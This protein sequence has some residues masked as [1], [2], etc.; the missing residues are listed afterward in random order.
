MNLK[1]ATLIALICVVIS[2][3]MWQIQSYELIKAV[4]WSGNTITA[5]K[6]FSSAATLINAFGF[7]IFFA[8]LY[9]KQK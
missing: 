7:V 8:T 4:S 1:A 2:A 6:T 9:T 3:L 5:A